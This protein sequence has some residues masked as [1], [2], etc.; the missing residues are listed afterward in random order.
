M[1]GGGGGDLHVSIN[2]WPFCRLYNDELS[3]RML[4]RKHWPAASSR[5]AVALSLKRRPLE[6]DISVPWGEVNGFI[7]RLSHSVPS[8]HQKKNNINIETKVKRNQFDR[9][10]LCSVCCPSVCPTLQST[11]V[12]IPWHC[13]LC[14]WGQSCQQLTT[15][16]TKM[17]KAGSHHSWAYS[18]F[19][20]YCTHTSVA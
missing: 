18:T 6:A 9:D 10:S 20:I 15:T 14:G 12:L 7:L 11:E 3:L 16:G 1:W 19:L 4:K 8:F 17:A 5:Q 13:S 2:D